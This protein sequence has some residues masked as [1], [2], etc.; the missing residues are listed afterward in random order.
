MPASVAEITARFGKMSCNTSRERLRAMRYS[1]F[2]QQVYLLESPRPIWR[3]H[4][5]ILTGSVLT[6][7]GYLLG[8]WSFSPTFGRP[9]ARFFCSRD[10]GIHLNKPNLMFSVVPSSQGKLTRFPYPR[11][12]SLAHKHTIL[13]PWCREKLCALF[14]I[15][16]R[17][18][19]KIGKIREKNTPNRGIL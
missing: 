19:G 1:P 16:G 10:S 2:F 17:Y 13:R 4:S 15:Q 14:C 6:I 7:F 3:K 9:K 8:P 12:R 11:D 18:L 5:G